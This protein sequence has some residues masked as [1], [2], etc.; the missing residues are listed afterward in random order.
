MQNIL[1][2]VLVPSFAFTT[3]IYFKNKLN[4]T[5]V[6]GYQY[7]QIWD[8]GVLFWKQQTISRFIVVDSLWITLCYIP[9]YYLLS[10]Y[11]GTAD[12]EKQILS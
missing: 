6:Y 1:V 2:S 10:S 5:Y 9:L 11:F 7:S 12:L 8:S 3:L 4:H